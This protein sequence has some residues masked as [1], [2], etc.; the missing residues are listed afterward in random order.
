MHEVIE[1]CR[2]CG[3]TGLVSLPDLGEQ[4][5][6]GVFPATKDEPTSCGPLELV[7]CEETP[8]DE[9]CGLVQLRQTYDFGEMYGLNYG[10]RSGLN[11]AMVEHLHNKVR[12]ILDRVSL[13]PGDLVLDIGSNDGTLLK[14]YP[15]DGPELV[16]MDPTGAKFE[17][18]YPRHIRL[19]SEPFS[20]DRFRDPF[21]GRKAK[22]VTAI[23][24]F[25]DLPDPLGF[26]RQVHDILAEDGVWVLEQSYLPAMLRATAYDTICHEHLEYYRLKGTSKNSPFSGVVDLESG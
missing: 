26:M 20:R 4:H 17:R 18:H 16:G 23:A 25:Y 3:N 9:S 6:T 14:A 19:I 10:Y 22:I 1:R 15:D 8:G 21:G 2:I 13:A 12:Y 24:M 11:A 5:L 7:K